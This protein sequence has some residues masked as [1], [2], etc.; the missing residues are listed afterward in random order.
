[1]APRIDLN[2][3][4][5]CRICGAE[6]PR[7]NKPSGRPEPPHEWKSRKVCPA[8]L[9]T[10]DEPCWRVAAK[11]AASLRKG[12]AK[13]RRE[14]EVV[15]APVRRPQLTEAQR[16]RLDG[17]QSAI[18]VRVHD[19]ICRQSGAYNGPVRHLTRTEIAALQHAYTPPA[20]SVRVQYRDWYCI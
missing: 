2:A 5:Y 8:N 13:K 15:K 20:E 11:T 17:E 7:C 14:L 4:V 18:N 16:E 1:M 12:E 9:D 3:K 6:I 19:R 10:K